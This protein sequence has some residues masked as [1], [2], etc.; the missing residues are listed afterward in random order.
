M[1]TVNQL[2]RKPRANKVARNKVPAPEG[3]A[4]APGRLHRASIR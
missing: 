4:A 1:P 3:L 2:I